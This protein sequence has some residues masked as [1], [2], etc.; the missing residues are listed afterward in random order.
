MASSSRVA[1]PDRA[2]RGPAGFEHHPEL[3]VVDGDGWS[4]KVLL[5]EVAGAVSPATTYTPIVGAELRVRPGYVKIPLRSDF[6]HAI[7]AVDGPVAVDGVDVAHRELRYLAPGRSEVGIQVPEES[8]LLLIGGE[9]FDEGLVMWWNFI[10]RSHDDIVEAREQ[11]QAAAARYGH[12][13]GH[14]GKVIP[15]PPLPDVRLTPRRRTL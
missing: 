12:V 15:A 13:D 4:A 10:G 8:T 14:G 5:G 1:L 2:R 9:P 7:L 3:P 6:E 11:W